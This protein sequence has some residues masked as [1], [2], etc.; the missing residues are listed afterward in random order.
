MSA[1]HPVAPVVAAGGV[2]GTDRGLTDPHPAG[3]AATGLGVHYRGSFCLV[4]VSP[5]I[6]FLKA[7]GQD[8]LIYTVIT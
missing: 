2:Q 3:P 7:L 6:M 5:H 1:I 4:Y 8:A